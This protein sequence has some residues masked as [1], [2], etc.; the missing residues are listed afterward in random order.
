MA[1]GFVKWQIIWLSGKIKFIY[2]IKNARA[3]IV[4]CGHRGNGKQK[5]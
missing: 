4:N 3:K 1:K 5:V 2:V